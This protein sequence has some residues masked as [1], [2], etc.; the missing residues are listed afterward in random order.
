MEHNPYNLNLTTKCNDSSIFITIISW[1]YMYLTQVI[2]YNQCCYMWIS[3]SD[4]SIYIKLNYLSM[5][6]AYF[7]ELFHN[8]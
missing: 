2:K 4:C 1:D 3:Q 7:I 5:T 6:Y 8:S